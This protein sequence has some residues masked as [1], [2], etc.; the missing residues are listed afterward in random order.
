MSTASTVETQ[1]MIRKPVATVF[2]AF[3]DPAIT[4]KFWFTKSSGPLE[5]GT[6]V[7]WEW[8]MYGVSTNVVVKE[9]IPNSRI[10]T[11]WG[12]PATAV[13]Y[14]F[15]ALTDETTYVV[16]R[17]WGYRQT[18][19]ELIAVIKDN[20]A[21]FTSVLDA[22]KAYL[23]HNIQLNLVLDKFPNKYNTDPRTL[24]EWQKGV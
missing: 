22:L 17:N 5:A 4:S 8:E 12:D 18:G 14:L 23:E 7:R 3:I 24:G 2:G 21:G 11:E 13:D 9:V 15:T 19:D 20:T 6:T 10:S 1:L 16:I